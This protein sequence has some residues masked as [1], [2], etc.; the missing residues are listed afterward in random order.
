MKVTIQILCERCQ[1][2][3]VAGYALAE[4][5]AT[6]LIDLSTKKISTLMTI[7]WTTCATLGKPQP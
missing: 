5:G 3:P 2:A 1:V 7:K 4:P 6:Q